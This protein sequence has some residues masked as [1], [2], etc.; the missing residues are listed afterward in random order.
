MNKKRCCLLL[1]LAAIMSLAGVSVRAADAGPGYDIEMSRMIRVRDGT[2]LE[3]WIT[4]PSNL[5]S[6]AT[7]ILTLTQYDIDGG[8]HADSPGAYARRGYVFV[9]VYVRG[10]GRSGGVKSENLGTQI[11]RDGY[12]LVEWIAAQPWSDGRVVMFGGSFVGMTQWQTAAQLPP[13]L[14][15]IAPY[16]PIYPG[17]DIPN[18]NG[19]P[20]AQTALILG[21]V[22]GRSLNTG[23]VNNQEYIAGKMLEQYA[24]NRPFSEL[25]HAI[26][27]SADDWWMPDEHGE[28]LS[29]MTMWLNHLGDAAFNLAAEPP[30][31]SYSRMNFPVLT[32]TGFYDDDQPGALHYYRNYVAHA[33][34]AAVARHH[35]VIGPWDHFASQAPS[36]T[37]GGIAIPEA[38]IIDMQKLHADWYDFVLGRGASP[39]LLHD[40]V[41]YF[42]LGAD[43][44]RYAK[45]L[46]AASSGKELT[47]F[48]SDS[49]GTPKDVFHSG[50]LM[51]KPNAQEPPAAIVSD[52]HELPELE[53]AKYSANEDL[54][55]QFR[56]Y[57]KRALTFH[58]DP[59]TQDTE[60]AGHMRLTLQ[61]AADAPDF[62]LWAQVL[63]VLPDGTAVRLGEDVRRARFRNSQFKEELVKA[64]QA[65][66]IPFEF[67]WLARRIPAGARIRLTIAPLN[68][69][70]YQKN[71][72]T[73][74]RLGYE[75]IEDAR[76]ANIKIF[77]DAKRASRLTLPL[78]AGAAGST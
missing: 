78:A 66:E 73:G 47:L 75:R 63:M 30:A 15:A 37:V 2:E 54:T 10:R 29:M 23:Y 45:S 56:A 40:T 61:C 28:K 62:D 14:A 33:P 71:F 77:H 39:A 64:G 41:A 35:L 43:E 68:S 50:G 60:I 32:V 16:V 8:R 58:S 55:S 1:W 11:G 17:W 22:S 3:A 69:P 72:N 20:Q 6:K 51:A 44:W 4:K 24:A 7:A 12:D 5:K 42:M 27:I 65:I 52:P 76:I 38:A 9:Q 18:T 70:N 67:Y 59:F 31:D 36:K 25:D 48:L 26:G 53:V 49:A 19:I 57:Q 46:Q 74:G 13:H 34:A 21:Y